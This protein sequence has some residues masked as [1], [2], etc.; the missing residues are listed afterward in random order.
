MIGFDRNTGSARLHPIDSDYVR[1]T[2]DDPSK[3]ATLD[4]R[5][6]DW[7]ATQRTDPKTWRTSS[8]VA[9]QR[10][11]IRH[12]LAPAMGTAPYGQW[13]VSQSS[14]PATVTAIS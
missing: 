2:L 1:G 13:P 14:L 4:L 5:L 12:R 9:P 6:A 3:R 7:L 10:Q 8:D 11:E